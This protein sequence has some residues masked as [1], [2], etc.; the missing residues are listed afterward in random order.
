[1]RSPDSQKFSASLYRKN[2]DEQLLM[3]NLHPVAH[4]EEP[5]SSTFEERQNKG[6]LIGMALGG[7][8]EAIE[9]EDEDLQ[10]ISTEQYELLR[11]ARK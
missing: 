1:M 3:R 6:N 8:L 5:L 9:S 10:R 2:T 7:A 4:F 11:R